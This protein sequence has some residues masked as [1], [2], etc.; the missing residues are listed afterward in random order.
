MKRGEIFG[1]LGPDGAGKTS[2]MRMLVG[3][4]EPSGGGGTVLGYD[5]ISQ[6]EEI[7]KHIGYVSQRFS[8]YGDLTIAENLD[9]FS[10]I[11]EVPVAERRERE[12]RM[13]E[14][15]RLEPFTKR[16]AQN[17]SGGMKQKLALAC[18]LMHQ[19]ELLFLDEPTTGVDPVSRRDFWK[20]LFQLVAEGM[21][22]VVSTPYMDE[23]ER[24]AKIAMID[25][26]R[27]VK[28]DTPAALKAAMKGVVIEV[29]ATPVRKAREA[30]RSVDSL[31]SVQ[32]YG[33]RL[34]VLAED[35]EAA[36]AAIAEALDKQSVQ[37]QSMQVMEAGLEDV[38]VSTIEKERMSVRNDNRA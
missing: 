3:I 20:I 7:K 11:H 8:I 9:F 38:F 2:L 4:L 37:L 16:L 14:F 30:L 32:F 1:I 23:A 24:C 18:T 26:G 22:L 10:E 12:E 25:V 29:V 21:T 31:E 17:L 19:P 27:V 6:R 33:N 36:K 34:H 28:V 15:S 13:L 35:V 5:L